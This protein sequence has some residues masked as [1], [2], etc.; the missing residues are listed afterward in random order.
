M[1]C[2]NGLFGRVSRKLV[3]KM[4]FIFG[5]YILY[6]QARAFPHENYPLKD[7]IAFRQ[8]QVTHF[9]ELVSHKHFPTAAV[10]LFFALSAFFCA[11][12]LLNPS[13]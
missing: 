3:T 7:F 2:S 11:Y 6:N 8:A 1:D 12:E 5:T 9:P 13:Q 4:L 10:S